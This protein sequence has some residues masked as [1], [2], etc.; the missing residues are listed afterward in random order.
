MTDDQLPPLDAL[1]VLESC[2]RNRSF[3]LAATE[4]RLSSESVSAQIQALE[5]SLNIT[6]FKEHGA[7]LEPTDSATALAGRIREGLNSFAAGIQAISLAGKS[8]SLKL[9]VSPDFANQFLAPRIDALKTSIPEL[10]VELTAETEPINIAGTGPTLAIVH[11]YEE[12]ESERWSQFHTRRMITDHKIVCCSSGLM[13]GEYPIRRASALCG[14]PLLKTAH[15]DRLW[16]N[17]LS[18]L[19]IDHPDPS[20]GMTFPDHASMQEATAQ[21]LG[22]GLISIADA[23]EGFSSGRLVAPLGETALFDMPEEHIPGFYLL[24]AKD[25]QQ[26]HRTRNVWDWLCEQQ[27]V[28]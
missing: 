16:Q 23:A 15:S 25:G 7:D 9:Y 17:V 11:G 21:G 4:L 5:H 26:Q 14:Y 28:D 24:C 6:L 19:E 8:E 22:I 12:W 18:H 1:Q 20:G 27:W 13:K 2:V 10:E 3:N